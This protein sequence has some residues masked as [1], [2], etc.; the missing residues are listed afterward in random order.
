[1]DTITKGGIVLNDLRSF[2]EIQVSW[3][4]Y[5]LHLQLLAFIPL[6]CVRKFVK[7]GQ[8]RQTQARLKFASQ[9]NFQKI[10]SNRHRLE[11]G[12]LFEPQSIN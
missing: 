1:M 7:S 11:K 10:S 4:R 3:L 2:L 9:D 8:L 6:C 12:W 5:E